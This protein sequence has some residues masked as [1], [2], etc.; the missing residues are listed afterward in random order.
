MTAMKLP[1]VILASVSPRRRELLRQLDLEFI[2]VAADTPELH[3]EDLTAWEISQL[4]AYR[5]A[6]YVAKRHPDALVIGADTLVC[7]GTRLFGK[8]ANPKEAAA[9]LA[10]LA[11]RT[12]T[13]VTGVCLLHLRSHR[14]RVFSETSFVTFHPLSPQ[15][16]QEYLGRV[17]ALDKAGA[18]AI[19][20]SG[21]LIVETV[22]GS[23]TN[24]VGLPLGR[25]REEL[26]LWR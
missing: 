12:H 6:R 25:L 23:L 11:D 2:T 13:V 14:Q 18:Y 24:V 22:V 21:E 4:N 10:A 9:M 8:P 20:E 7:L 26:L 15:R 17:H 1:P 5:K 16:I 3:Q 19:Q